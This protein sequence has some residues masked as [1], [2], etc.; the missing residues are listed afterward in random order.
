[1]IR[2]KA[3]SLGRRPTGDGLL[4]RDRGNLANACIHRV[5]NLVFAA[6][7]GPLQFNIGENAFF[8]QIAAFL[9]LGAVP[10]DAHLWLCHVDVV[11]R[12]LVR[13]AGAADSTNQTHHLEN[14]R[15]GFLADF[16]APAEGVRTCGFD[17][18]LER[19]EAA[20]D[21]PEMDGALA[22]TLETFGL[23][24]GQSPQ[25]RAR[26]QEIVSGR[27]QALLARLGLVWPEAPAAGQAEMLRQAAQSLELAP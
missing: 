17:A 12:G 21:D 18:F 1:V 4:F 26:R 19:L 10:D 22:A 27:T 20:V 11:A 15:R 14:A 3:G 8:Q 24:C 7:G 23:H 25:A 9:R 5:G 16:V 6:E 13:L 2:A